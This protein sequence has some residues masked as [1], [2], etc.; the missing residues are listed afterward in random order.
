MSISLQTI[1]K[2]SINELV[3][4]ARAHGIDNAGNM[5]KS[6]LIFSLICAATSR[7]KTIFGDGILEIL[8]EGFGFL[9]S[10]V[11]DFGPG[12][13]DIYVSPAQIRRFN[14][15][16]GDF[17]EGKARTPQKEGE[18]YLAL[19][20]I[21]RVNGQNPED[22]RNRLLFETL[23]LRESTPAMFSHGSVESWTKKQR[24]YNGQ[25][26]LIRHYPGQSCIRALLPFLAEHNAEVVYLSMETPSE[27]LYVLNSS[28]LH[29]FISP[30]GEG[31]TRHIQIA[32]LAL[33]RAKRLAE[34]GKDVVL[35]FDSLWTY[36][37]S[38]QEQVKQQGK[39][40]DFSIACSMFRYFWGSARQFENGSLSIYA[41]LPTNFCSQV[42]KVEAQL[43]HHTHHMVYLY[44]QLVQEGCNPPLLSNDGV[45]EP[46]VQWRAFTS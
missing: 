38:A 26:T 17:I 25:R 15:R 13:D 31:T 9:R 35:V 19:L 34:L 36:L 3:E 40:G 22:S 41:L 21:E 1:R 8:G 43:L 10:P 23:T 28:S 11:S 4:Q 5:R 2:Q 12:T 27:D 37:L 24:M 20:Q 7:G 18:R 45:S 44:S 16:S 30:M 32:N 6:D 29:T 33:M 42:A 14:L 46:V 39:T